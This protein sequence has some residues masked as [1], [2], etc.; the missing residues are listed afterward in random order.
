MQTFAFWEQGC[1]NARHET[2]NILLKFEVAGDASSPTLC[3]SV[4]AVPWTDE[5]EQQI[6]RLALSG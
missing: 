2:E 3:A 4:R 6:S 1:R 5:A